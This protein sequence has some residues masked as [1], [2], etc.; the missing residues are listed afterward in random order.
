MGGWHGAPARGAGKGGRHGTGGTRVGRMGRHGG[1]QG[2]RHGG[3]HGGLAGGGRHGGAARG[4]SRRGRHGE[5][6]RAGGKGGVTRGAARGTGVKDIFVNP[7]DN[8]LSLPKRHQQMVLHVL[9]AL[10]LPSLGVCTGSNSYGGAPRL[11]GTKPVGRIFWQLVSRIFNLHTGMYSC[12]ATGCRIA[13]ACLHVHAAVR[14]TSS[15]R[16]PLAVH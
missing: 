1:W 2:G 16:S 3:R 4:A 11:Y 15:Y 8:S 5:Q 9:H 7:H 14:P 10:L 12:D 13:H 6:A